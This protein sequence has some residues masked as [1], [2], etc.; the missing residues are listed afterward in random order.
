M[1]AGYICFIA[2]LW[3]ASQRTF[4][5]LLLAFCALWLMRWAGLESIDSKKTH[6]GSGAA[7]GI[8]RIFRGYGLAV[9]ILAIAT[10]NLAWRNI[11]EVRSPI[12]NVALKSIEIVA[13]TQSAALLPLL[14]RLAMHKAQLNAHSDALQYYKRMLEI[15]GENPTRSDASLPS[16][17]YSIAIEHSH[18]KEYP[19]AISYFER[20]LAITSSPTEQVLGLTQLARLYVLLDFPSKALELEDRAIA[21]AETLDTNN[22]NLSLQGLATLALSY[23]SA[24]D[25]AHALQLASRS[26]ALS[27][28][29]VGNHHRASAISLYNLGSL[30][31]LLGNANE[32]LPLLQEALRILELFLAPTDIGLSQVLSAIHLAYSLIGNHV[33]SLEFA[34][35]NLKIV[36]A[37]SAVS[38]DVV[39]GAL[40]SVA[41]E[42]VALGST[43]KARPMLERSLSIREKV[44]GGDSAGVASTLLNLAT[45]NSATGDYEDAISLTNRAL[46]IDEKRLGKKATNE[47]GAYFAK[48]YQRAGRFEES[49]PLIERSAVDLALSQTLYPIH[50][51]EREWYLFHLFSTAFA[52]TKE[53][54]AAIFF[55][56]QAVN[57]VQR[58]L[59]QRVGSERDF[60]R[61]FLEQR[62]Y[63]YASLA[64]LLI[65][66]RQIDEA[67]QIISMLKESEY[68]DFIRR[69]VL[70]ETRITSASLTVEEQKWQK[71]YEKVMGDVQLTGP[72]SRDAS[73]GELRAASAKLRDALNM[74]R[75]ESAV[76]RDG[77]SKSGAR[78]TTPPSLLLRET[79][80]AT[81]QSAALLQ[82]LIT[83]TQ[84]QIIL[85]TPTE[86]VIGKTMI[87]QDD[88]A[89]KVAVFGAVLA[90][91]LQNPLPSAKELY[92]LLWAPVALELEKRNIKDVML[93]LDGILRYVPFAA[94]NDGEHYLVERFNLSNFTEV[95]KANVK[96]TS[97][98]NLRVAALGSTKALGQF[99]A[100]PAVRQELEGI[101]RVMSQSADSTGALPGEIYYDD[102]FTEDRLRRASSAFSVV[103][104]ASHFKLV[105]GAETESFLLL[106]DGN[107][108]TL[109]DV[110]SQKWNMRTVELF[111]LSACETAIGGRADASGGEI[112]GFGVLLQRLGAKSVIASLWQ[113]SDRSTSV[114]MRAFYRRWQE[115]G[116]SKSNALRQAQMA[117]LLGKHPIDDVIR[118]GVRQD[119]RAGSESAHDPARPYAHP[120]YWAPFI[121]MGNWL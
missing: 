68:F 84:L 113:V 101:V 17:L 75:A 64:N 83:D 46:K 65:E 118:N 88:L 54:G 29:L 107:H 92:Q 55:G 76:K 13:G 25:S 57:S 18:L 77:H 6:T 39:A 35:R 120:F 63:V 16:V 110:R 99:K 56:K 96:A 74:I 104:V 40:E 53:I 50:S 109:A 67:Q 41:T 95:A 21:I 52:G 26:V 70:S 102:A 38:D 1:I 91:P 47:Y 8:L 60:R 121:L 44:D 115:D 62:R 94:L 103:H 27:Q 72:R 58:V 61:A 24:G 114:L 51:Q 69:D 36:E 85:T 81:G 90:N 37:T 49:I 4:V 106:G 66:N 78:A 80:K 10:G 100:M 14:D 33:K 45:I 7:V 43:R 108:L 105:T 3:A 73:D 2:G 42:Y 12:L 112:E 98:G 87:G 32:G 28:K 59:P 116:I 79:V 31:L 34:E 22:F 11:P 119:G 111:T 82:Y 20:A 86:Q 5:P 71:L 93:S 15:G 23:A 9:L 89:R 117:L 19:I 30:H 97:H 48:I